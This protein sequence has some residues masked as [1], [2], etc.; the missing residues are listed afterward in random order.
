MASTPTTLAYFSQN[1]AEEEQI[2]FFGSLE[3]KKLGSMT[4]RCIN[5]ISLLAMPAYSTENDSTNQH[6]VAVHCSLISHN[7]EECWINVPFTV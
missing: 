6:C 2:G 4:L 7:L 5:L 3:R 1:K